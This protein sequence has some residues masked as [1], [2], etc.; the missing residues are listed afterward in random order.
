MEKILLK[1]KKEGWETF[2]VEISNLA[3]EYVLKNY[4]LNIFNGIVEDAGFEDGFFDL[5]ILSQVLEHLPY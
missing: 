2:G 4:G 1:L 3:A 5:I